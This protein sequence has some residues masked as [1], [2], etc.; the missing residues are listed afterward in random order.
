MPSG[1]LDEAALDSFPEDE[2]SPSTFL[3][4]STSLVS[5]FDMLPFPGHAESAGSRLSVAI[6]PR[7][8]GAEPAL[9]KGDGL[10]EHI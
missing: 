6:L 2:P 7:M 1:M 4:L 3:P 5:V 10:S 8:L 9:R